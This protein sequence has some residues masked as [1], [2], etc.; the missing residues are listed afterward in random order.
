MDDEQHRRCGNPECACGCDTCR[1]AKLKGLK[2]D[3]PSIKSLRDLVLCL[4]DYGLYVEADILCLHLN[5]LD[6]ESAKKGHNEQS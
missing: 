5:S 6:R 3:P 1:E 4:R 2:E